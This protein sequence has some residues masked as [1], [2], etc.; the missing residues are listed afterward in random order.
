MVVLRHVL[1]HIPK[2]Y[3]FLLLLKSVFK[4]SK[5]YIEVPEFNWIKK[6]KLF[7]I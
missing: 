5:I 4:K 6:I 2:P 1:E 3:E 7:L